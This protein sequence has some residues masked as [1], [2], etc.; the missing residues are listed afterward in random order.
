MKKTELVSLLKDVSPDPRM[1]VCYGRGAVFKPDGHFIRVETGK[2]TLVSKAL[3]VTR[4]YKCCG[5]C[6]N[7]RGDLTVTL[8]PT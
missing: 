1:A 4:H 6:P 2:R 3:C 8:K 5:L 7:S